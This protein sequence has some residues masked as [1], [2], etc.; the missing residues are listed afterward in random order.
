M[1]GIRCRALK[2]ENQRTGPQGPKPTDGRIS[3][4]KVS[5]LFRLDSGHHS[6]HYPLRKFRFSQGPLRFQQVVYFDRQLMNGGILLCQPSKRNSILNPLPEIRRAL[7]SC[8][9]I[10]EI[11][12]CDCPWRLNEILARSEK[13]KR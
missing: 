13:A 8:L 4:G 10:Y 6:L 5:C 11:A 7:S 1:L 12:H 2:L 3:L 9:W